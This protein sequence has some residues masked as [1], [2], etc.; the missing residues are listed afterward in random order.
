MGN[1]SLINYLLSSGCH[2]L[3]IRMSVKA[4]R[5]TSPPCIQLIR[6]DSP[7]TASSFRDSKCSFRFAST[8]LS[9]S[10]VAASFWEKNWQCDSSLSLPLSC[11]LQ[12][13]C[14]L[15]SHLSTGV[16]IS[17]IVCYHILLLPINWFLI[18]VTRQL[19]GWWQ[20]ANGLVGNIKEAGLCCGPLTTYRLW[21]MAPN[22]L[23]SGY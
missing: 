11:A 18:A 12:R 22:D 9:P 19:A 4:L 17:W 14:L 13:P 8:F 7:P 3:T 16:H 5:I 23:L 2:E 1:I 21:L 20:S 15:S 6:G 10:A